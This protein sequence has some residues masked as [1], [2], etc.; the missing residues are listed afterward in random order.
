MIH[1]KWENA[2][3][4]LQ[5]FPENATIWVSKNRIVIVTITS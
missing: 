5:A 3:K 2:K 4:L 1:T